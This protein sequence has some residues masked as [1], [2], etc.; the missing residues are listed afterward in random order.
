MIEWG[1][2]AVKGSFIS[3]NIEP[4]YLRVCWWLCSFCS[5]VCLCGLSLLIW[6][7]CVGSQCLTD[8]VLCVLFQC[9]YGC[10]V[11][12][13]I[14]P[15]FHRRCYWLLQVRVQ[16]LP[17]LFNINDA[18]DA[19][20]TRNTPENIFHHHPVAKN[21]VFLSSPSLLKAWTVQQRWQ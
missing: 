19:G 10:Y 20:L 9:L 13:S 18:S 4:L 1:N 21:S 6:C 14:I 15:T 11:H 2:M 16:L 8:G 17:L 3:A 7:L 5:C 12:S